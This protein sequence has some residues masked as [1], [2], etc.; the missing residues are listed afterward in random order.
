MTII[1]TP[2]HG[3]YQR[4]LSIHTERTPSPAIMQQ[5]HETDQSPPFSVEVKN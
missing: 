5:G 1:N 4:Q 3:L 2:C